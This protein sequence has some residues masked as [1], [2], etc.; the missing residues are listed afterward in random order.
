[1]W[2]Q[3]DYFRPCRPYWQHIDVSCIEQVMKM[4]AVNDMQQCF[5]LPLF[6]LQHV[7]KSCR[8]CTVSTRWRLYF[9]L[10]NAHTSKWKYARDISKYKYLSL[11]II[12][13]VPKKNN[14]YYNDSLATPDLS[15][16]PFICC[17]LLIF[18]H[19]NN[20]NTFCSYWRFSSQS[21]KSVVAPLMP[22]IIAELL[23]LKFDNEKIIYKFWQNGNRL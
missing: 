21:C 8:I 15:T 5:C 23:W 12:C 10:S 3:N 13:S 9:N 20:K 2:S 1:M 17:L 6:P 7:S 14:I 22:V 16:E 11:H 18:I 4:L 19:Q